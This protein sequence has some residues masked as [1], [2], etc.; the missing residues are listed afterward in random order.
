MWLILL[1]VLLIAGG[2]VGGWLLGWPLWIE[3]SLSALIVLVTVGIIVF[4][5][6]RAIHAA[7]AL[8]REILAQAEK[9]A[10]TARPDHRAEILALQ[11]KMKQGIGALKKS[12]LAVASG[13]GALYSLPWYVI[14]GP[15]GAGK[16]TALRHSGLVF[17]FL[18]PSQDGIKGLGGTRNCDWWFTNE[19][20]LLDTAGRYATDDDD[21]DEWFA[22]LD[23]L[24]KHRARTPINGMLVAISV[25]DLAGQP[26]ERIEQAAQI[27]RARIDEV[28]SRLQM[29]VPVYVVF[30]KMDLIDGFV[31]FWEDLRKS[32]REQ[33]WGMSFELQ[34]PKDFEPAKQFAKEFDLL[35]ER[36]HARSIARMRTTRRA[37]ARAKVL[38]FPLEFTSLKSDLALFLETLFQKNAYQETPLFRGAYFTSGTQEGRPL[39]RVMAGMASAFGLRLDTAPGTQTIDPKSYFLTEMFQKVVFPDRHLA[40]RTAVEARRRMWLQVGVGVGAVSLGAGIVI[41]G[42][43]GYLNNRTLIQDS[44]SETQQ[45]RLVDPNDRGELSSRIDALS[46]LRGHLDRLDRWEADGADW[47]HR[48]GM[49]TGQTLRPA[50]QAKYASTMNESFVIPSKTRLE[51][52]L[53]AFHAAGQ[54]G[55]I[56]PEVYVRYYD[57]LK[58]YLMLTEAEHLDIAWA[59]PRL[60]SEWAEYLR[61]APTDRGASESLIRKYLELQKAMRVAP[62]TRDEV[63][64]AQARG[65]LRNTPRIL[66]DFERLMDTIR[67]GTVPI[68]RATVFGASAANRYIV[69]RAGVSVDGV[70]TRLGWERVKKE[71][72]ALEK[73]MAG[74]AWVLGEGSF[75]PKTAVADVRKLYF[76][77]HTIA[78]ERFLR[79]LDIEKP[80]NVEEALP[81][82][83]ALTEPEWPVLRLARVVQDNVVL[84]LTAQEAGFKSSVKDDLGAVMDAAKAIQAGDAGAVLAKPHYPSPMERQFRQFLQFSIPPTPDKADA[85]PTPTALGQ[86]HGVLSKLIAVLTDHKNKGADARGDI[87]PLETEFQEA[88]RAVVK[89]LAEQDSYT[90]EL[91]QNLLLK[92]I[93]LSWGSVVNDAAGA[94][95]AFWEISVYRQCLTKLHSAYPFVADA[96]RDVS[97]QDF[98]EFFRPE[99]GTL[100][101]FY[102]QNIKTS[103][104]KR[105]GHFVPSQRFEQ[106]SP[107]SIGFLRFLERSDEITQTF[108][109]DGGKTPSVEFQINLHSVSPNVAEVTLEI[110]GKPFTYKNTP[111][112]WMVVSWP[113]KDAKTRGAKIR[114]RGLSGLVEELLNE[115]D[116]GLF[117]L[118]ARAKFDVG[119]AGGRPGEPKT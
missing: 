46:H 85:P 11:D 12:K 94:S 69:S 91:L 47:N 42:L 111:E 82:L 63:L 114:I 33:M 13:G 108:F 8:E 99:T 43:I 83:L 9:H 86:Y 65:Q 72:D 90:R 95:G 38:Q 53:A 31:E 116:F 50:V 97:L 37:E 118:L 26:E 25:T 79:D 1:A 117:R 92:P 112:D 96:Q 16:T 71:L 3:I 6:L 73:T 98:T 2:W 119:T 35:T 61:V 115:G 23:I 57:T 104:E 21:R 78:W 64:T 29:V 55:A 67:P 34:R 27:L 88:Y 22:F 101:S 109:D 41:P 93:T 54:A 68:G 77:K 60:G 48:F 89:M 20:V 58:T 113:A 15:P 62:A 105:A 51:Q 45:A 81:Q 74:E 44:L 49:Y 17:P 7:R 84:E 56:S 102:N 103:V 39:D 110:D 100:W 10:A 5:R 52:R 18:D 4:R 75:D 66:G 70:Y 28:I 107:Y 40:V 14:V 19:A 59:T 76:E 32:E 36:V 24:K 87:K 30:T 80:R 106:K